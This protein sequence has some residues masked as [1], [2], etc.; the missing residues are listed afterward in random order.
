[1]S[2]YLVEFLAGSK[3]VLRARTRAAKLHVSARAL[4]PGT[5]RWVVWGLNNRGAPTGKPLVDSS[6]RIRRG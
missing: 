2:G 6:V 3:I 1:V 4:R 5:Y